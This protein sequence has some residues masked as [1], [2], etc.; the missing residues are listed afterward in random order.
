MVRR[1]AGSDEALEAVAA[2]AA[3]LGF[4]LVQTVTVPEAQ[5]EVA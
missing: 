4:D 1:G 3:A 2:D 5:S